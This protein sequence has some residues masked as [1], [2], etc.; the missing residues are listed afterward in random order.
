MTN[1]FERAIDAVEYVSHRRQLKIAL[2]DGSEHLIPVDR[3]QMERW[4]GTDIERL[5]RP[6]DSQLATVKTWGGGRSIVFPELEQVFL[7]E[8][9]VAGRYGDSKWMSEM[10]AGTV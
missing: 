7:V 5:P 8:D 4:N 6:S 9:L 2:S 10:M 3:L 1:E